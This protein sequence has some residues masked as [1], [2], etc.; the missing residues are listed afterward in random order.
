M[1]SYL[2]IV[3]AKTDIMNEGFWADPAAL[4]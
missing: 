4:N 1:S 3:A 2:A